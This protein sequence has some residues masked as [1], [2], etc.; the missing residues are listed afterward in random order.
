MLVHRTGKCATCKIPIKIT[1]EFAVTIDMFNPDAKGINKEV[2]EEIKQ[3][4]SRPIFCEDHK[5]YETA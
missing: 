2:A 4:R 1:R 5:Q 3:W